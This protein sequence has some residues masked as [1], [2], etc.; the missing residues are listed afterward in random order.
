[1]LRLANVSVWALHFVMSASPAWCAPPAAKDATIIKADSTTW[2]ADHAAAELGGYVRQMT[3]ANV[4]IVSDAPRPIKNGPVFVLSLG[5]SAKK[6]KTL[7]GAGDPERLRDGFV[8]RS[9]GKDR[10]LIAAAEPIGLLYGVYTYLEKVCGVGFFWDGER[11]PKR[12]DLPTS[13][14][15]RAELPRF[16]I[17]QNLQACAFGYTTQ[18][19]GLEEW[20]R[21]IDWTARKRFNTVMLPWGDLTKQVF[22]KLGVNLGDLTPEEAYR[23]DLA[24]QIAVYARQRGIRCILPG[25]AGGVPKEFAKAHPKARYVNVKWLE[26]AAQPHLYPADPWFARVGELVVRTYTD[27]YGTDHIYNIDP[28]PETQPGASPEEKAAIK[29]DF[30]KGVVRYLRAADPKAVW[31]ASG[32]AFLDQGFWPKA[33]VS[34]HLAEIPDEM[35]YVCDIQAEA[36]PIYQRL[37]YLDGKR[38]GFSVLHSFGGDDHLHG[39]MA[40]LVRRVQAVVSDPRAGGCVAFYINPEIIHYNVPYF[41]LAAELGWNPDG[42]AVDAFC[43]AYA[44]R[45][46][47]P[48]SAETMCRA[49]KILRETVYGPHPGGEP[50]WQRRLGKNPA[51]ALHPIDFLRVSPLWTALEE[52]IEIALAEAPRQRGNPMYARDIVDWTRQYT[53]EVFG[54]VIARAGLAF[55]RGDAPKLTQCRTRALELMRQVERL[56]STHPMYRISTE[57]ARGRRIPGYSSEMDYKLKNIMFSFASD[58]WVFLL[59]YQSKDMQELMAGYDRPRVTAWFDAMEAALK[60]GA[61]SYDEAALA[62]RYRTIEKAF[63]ERPLEEIRLEPAGDAATIAR[64]VFACA[65]QVR[66]QTGIRPMAGRVEPGDR[67][68]WAEDFSSVEDWFTTFEGGRFETDGNVARLTSQR[69]WCLVGTKLDVDPGAFPVLTFRYRCPGQGT[70][71]AWIWVTWADEKGHETR[72]LVWNLGTEKDWTEV[73]LDLHSLLSMIGKPKKVLRIELNNQ[74]PPHVSEW[75][76]VRLCS[77]K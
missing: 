22:R 28:Y 15:D 41:E 4:R 12:T 77:R 17:R 65:K 6:L 38:W 21:E 46:Y 75:D 50:R 71:A 33:S 55:S 51:G 64:E 49:L 18:Y 62:Q 48:A 14:I 3:G 40:D 74:D 27:V 20:K 23:I 42:V 1:M 66:D 25:F 59:D 32:W 53:A 47:G 9:E 11:V 36:N 68:G 24:R 57:Q 58:D 16:R 69:K 72:S 26:A 35:Y 67:V 73:H 30:A 61:G 45:R 37:D 44:R 8:I 43:K 63:L 52:V 2:L 10:L 70:Q 7:P 13:G 19:W 31:Y 76:F 39:N 5:E 29:I 54:R 60:S 56:L 34:K